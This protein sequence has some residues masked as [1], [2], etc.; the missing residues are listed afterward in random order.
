MP[1]TSAGSTNIP[2]GTLVFIARRKSPVAVRMEARVVRNDGCE[3]AVE[4]PD[5][6]KVVPGEVWNLHYN[7]RPSVCELDAR[8]LRVEGREFI[9]R[10]V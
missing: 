2:V 8:L 4:L 9:F 3:F 10:P 6:L 1:D 7:S 5:V